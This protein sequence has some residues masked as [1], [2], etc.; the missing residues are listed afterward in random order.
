[1]QTVSDLL[2]HFEITCRAMWRLSPHEPQ[3]VL[4]D[5]LYDSFMHTFD[6]LKR[7]RPVDEV[8]VMMRRVYDRSHKHIRG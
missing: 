5:F 3:H 6:G 2:R 4:E 1:M 7:Y 8:T